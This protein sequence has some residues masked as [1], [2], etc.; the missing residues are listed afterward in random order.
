[1]VSENLEEGQSVHARHLKVQSDNIRLK[2]EDLVARHIGIAGIPHDL[3][4]GISGE[5]GTNGT[6]SQ[7]RIVHD[8][9]PNWL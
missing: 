6:T 7:C 4:L 8:Q 3:D 9:H 1:M 2:G 5:G